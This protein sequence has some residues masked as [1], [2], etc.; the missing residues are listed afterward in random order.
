M[1]YSLSDLPPLLQ[2]VVDGTTESPTAGGPISQR[3]LE[4]G[5]E[6]RGPERPAAFFDHINLDEALELYAVVR[7]LAPKHSLEIGFCSGVSGLAILQALHDA[8]GGIHHV[9]DPF[10]T[11]YAGRRGLDNVAAAGF[12]ALLD[13]HEDYPEMVVPRLPPIQFCFIDASHLFDLSILDFVLADKRLEVGGILALHD[14]WMPALQAVVR[15]V[16]SNR[17]YRIHHSSGVV[18]QPARGLKAEAKRWVAAVLRRLPRAEQYFTSSVLQ[19]WE[20]LG[21]TNLVFLEKTDGDE[22]DWKTHRPF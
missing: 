17:S 14:L 13:F 5:G 21:I 12:S 6:A 19:P 9:C 18:P 7:T 2:R 11:T 20:S 10:Q 15:Y 1:R 8:G 16:L 22:R 3:D 4:A